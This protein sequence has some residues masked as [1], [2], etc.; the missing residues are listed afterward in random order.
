MLT[1]AARGT[2]FNV[3]GTG[4]GIFDRIASELSGYYLLGVEPAGPDRDGKAHAIGV[5]VSRRGVMVRSRR[6]M[7]TATGAADALAASPRD[8]AMAALAEPFLLTSLP[9][10]GIAFA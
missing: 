1:S 8:A 3:T 6:T 4:T 10:R 7:L 9:M 2:L 5:D